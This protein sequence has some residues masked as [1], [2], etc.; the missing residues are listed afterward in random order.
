VIAPTTGIEG[1]KGCA[2]ITTF[3]DAIDVQPIAFVT[4]KVR[5]PDARLEMV[6]FSPVPASTPGFIIQFPAGKPLNATLPVETEQV[7]CVIAP[8]IGAEGVA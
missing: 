4:V 3:A 7:G 6:V 5:V 2:L 1:V 8:I